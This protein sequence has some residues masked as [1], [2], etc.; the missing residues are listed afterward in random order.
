LTQSVAALIGLIIVG[1]TLLW[2]QVIT[3]EVN[4]RNLEKKYSSFLMTMREEHWPIS[5]DGAIIVQLRRD[6]FKKIKER[7]LP[8]EIYL[9]E[10]SK[11]KKHTYVFLDICSLIEFVSSYLD[12]E[13]GVWM[14]E[15]IEDL[16]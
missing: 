7:S 6:Y 2:S 1:I 4:L 11:Y 14:E 15:T 13:R 10:H 5:E 16:K 12:V 9:Y 3:E 8:D